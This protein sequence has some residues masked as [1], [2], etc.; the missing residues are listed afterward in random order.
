MGKRFASHF[1][2][3]VKNSLTHCMNYK[4]NAVQE[5]RTEPPESR[6]ARGKEI[7]NFGTR[8]H[9]VDLSRDGE[10]KFSNTDQLLV[11]REE[12]RDG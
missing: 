10:G 1:L 12:S 4:Y 11:L 5:I 8:K 9:R 7:P 6:G 3:K 2:R